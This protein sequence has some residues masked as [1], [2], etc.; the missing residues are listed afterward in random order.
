ITTHTL[1]V[2][3]WNSLA[4]EEFVFPMIPKM[5]PVP[6]IKNDRFGI[7][8]AGMANVTVRI[9]EG[10]STVPE[11]CT[12]LGVCEVELPF[13]LPKGAPVEL[14]Y[15]YDENQVLEVVIEAYNRQSRV[16]IAR[17]LGLS[18]AEIADATADLR[19]ITVV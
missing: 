14:T 8:K 12:P 2:V 5:T 13:P 10:E 3:L 7:A 19:R 17:N 9:V 16:Q 15:R 6:A 11:E 4:G 1:G 18:E